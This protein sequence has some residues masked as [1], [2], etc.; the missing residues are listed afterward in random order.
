MD[1]KEKALAKHY[2]WGGKIE[3]VS[4]VSVTSSEELSTAYTPGV[5]APC[6]V[7]HEDTDKSYELTRRSNLVA[8]ITDGNK[9]EST[10]AEEEKGP[11]DEGLEEQNAKKQPGN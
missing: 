9:I 5:A 7:I 3:V 10:T 11:V 1:I 6:M 8:V 4:R 2:E